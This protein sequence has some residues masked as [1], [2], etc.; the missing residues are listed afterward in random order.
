MAA[1]RR[2]GGRGG[3]CRPGLV[4]IALALSLPGAACYTYTQVSPAAVVPGSS[5]RVRIAAQAALPPGTVPRADGT[6]MVQGTLLRGSSAD[7]L[8]CAVPLTDGDP[9]AGSRG[10]SGTALVPVADV[11]RVEVR[12]LQKGRTAAVLG[13]GTLLGLAVVR[14]AFDVTL[15]SKQGGEQPGGG[16][17]ARRVLLQLRW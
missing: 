4:L 14:W 13:A 11:E 10:L 8:V 16:N 1:E 7:T 5:V 17:N 3:R 2:G 12:H 9:I 15:P 6:R